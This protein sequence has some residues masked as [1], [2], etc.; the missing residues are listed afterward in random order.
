MPAQHKLAK[1]YRLKKNLCLVSVTPIFLLDVLTTL[2]S[3]CC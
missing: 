2:V 1:N 3:L